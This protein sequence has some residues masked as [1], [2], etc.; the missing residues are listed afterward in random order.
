MGGWL[1]GW[2][3]GS[4]GGPTFALASAHTH[5]HAHVHAHTPP[6]QDTFT[7]MISVALAAALNLCGDFLLVPHTGIVG[8][9]IATAVSQYAAAM[10]LLRQ[11]HKKA[12]VGRKVFKPRP[13]DAVNTA[14]AANA[15][16]DKDMIRFLDTAD[17]SNSA[18]SDKD[19]VRF[20]DT[21][22]TVATYLPATPRAW[23]DTVKP[24]FA[25]GPFFLCCIIKQASHTSA[26]MSAA[27]GGE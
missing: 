24:F 6:S 9:A 8:A 3:V 20:L 25:F 22:R 17:T 11:L 19:V 7:P 2:L 18:A 16:R 13:N 14:N 23:F 26:A 21:D 10:L 12:F 5:S 1:V 27:A 4:V 15:A